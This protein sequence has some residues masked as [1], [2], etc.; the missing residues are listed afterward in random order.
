[1]SDVIEEKRVDKST[2]DNNKP[3]YLKV[4]DQVFKDM[5]FKSLAGT[6]NIIQ[7]LDTPEKLAFV[8]TYAHLLNNVFYLKLEQDYWEHYNRVCISED[9]WSAPMEK[10]LAKQNNLCRFKFKTKTQLEKH[11][12]LILNRLQETEKNLNKHKQ[13]PIHG[14]VDMNKLSAVVTAFVRQGQN[15]LSTAFE[16]KKLIL[17]F[18]A[19][20]HCLVKKFYDMKP[21]KDQV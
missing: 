8:R 17:Q 14:S 4:P 15:K 3:K 5:L 7:L 12:Q 19:N 6:D 11:R 2:S 20:D 1:M 21:T 9:I 13:Q 18:D 10:D 16:Q